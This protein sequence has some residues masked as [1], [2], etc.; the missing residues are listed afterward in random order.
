VSQIIKNATSGGGGGSDLEHLTGNT[1][2][3][4]NGDGAHNI[5][6]VTAGTTV[7]FAGSGSTLTQDFG[8]PNLLIGS[9]GTNLTSGSFNVALGDGAL[10]DISSGG[11][12]TCIGYFTGGSIT[13]G[14]N[15]T[16]VGGNCGSSA[17]TTTNNVGMGIDCLNAFTTGLTNLGANVAVGFAVLDNLLTGVYNSAFG[18][19]AG[20]FY[21]GSESSNLVIQN[22]GVIGDHNTIRIGDQGVSE[23]QQ[24]KCFIAGIAGVSISNQTIATINSSTG[25]LGNVTSVPIANGGTNAT[26]MSTSNGIVKYNGTS[27][28]TSTTAT[29]D[30]SNR[31]TNT[32]Q[33]AF[34]AYLSATASN[35]TGDG[36]TYQIA[37]DTVVYDTAGGF[38]TGG[39]AHYTFPVTGKY[40]ISFGTTSQGVALGTSG[41]FNI[42]AT[43]RTFQKLET[44]VAASVLC[45]TMTALVDAT[46]NDT[47]NITAAIFGGA[48]TG[49]IL[50][51][52]SPYYTWVTGVL[53]C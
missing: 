31:M 28:V 37:Y 24:N 33:P 18:F 32:S 34:M 35:V 14:N 26:S 46:A 30:A 42:V 1:G 21:T 11:L 4:L 25:Q 17:T 50:G 12:N 27:L 20:S 36:T 39:S 40:L 43:S 22:R 29:I 2:G 5:N 3:P 23:G 6:I 19:N 9:S 51:S 15:N 52:A 16:F 49:N 44:I 48:K 13:S 38:T 10:N 8:L 45:D 7:I 53:I 41:I 47:V